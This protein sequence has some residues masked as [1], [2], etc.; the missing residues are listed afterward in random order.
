QLVFAALVQVLD[1]EVLCAAL[2]HRSGAAADDG[3][4]H[5]GGDQH[6]DAV[7]VQGVEGLEFAAVDQEIQTA[8]GEDS[9]HVENGQFHRLGALLQVSCHHITPARSRSCMFSA[10]TGR[11]SSSITTRALILWSSIIFRASAASIS[12]RAVLPWLVI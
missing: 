2:D 7:A 6:L 4:G 11:F 3:A 8:I 10:P 12:A 9:V 5:A 1:A